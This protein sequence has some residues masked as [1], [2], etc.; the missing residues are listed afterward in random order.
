MKKEE[1]YK[2]VNSYLKPE[3]YKKK[4]SR[5]NKD[6]GDFIAV[7]FLQRSNYSSQYYISIGV[8]FKQLLPQQKFDYHISIRSEYI[9]GDN[10]IEIFNLENILSDDI[11]KE[12]I[13]KAINEL[14]PL[15]KKFESLQGIE[16]IIHKYTSAI[17]ITTQAR[18]ILKKNEK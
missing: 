8:L 17:S 1:L 11:R 14:I 13:I 2:I 4:G 5:W 10:I 12:K 9:F 18:G 15:L 3:G 7:F 16:E 6:V